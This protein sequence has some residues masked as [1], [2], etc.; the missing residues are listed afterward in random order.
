MRYDF[1]YMKMRVVKEAN[2]QKKMRRE[3]KTERIQIKKRKR[4][5]KRENISRKN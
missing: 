4:R 3:K 1:F 2:T 5:K